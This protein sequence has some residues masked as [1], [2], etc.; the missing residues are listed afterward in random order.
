MTNNTA[1]YARY[2][3]ER[4]DGLF[5]AL[6]KSMSREEYQQN[7]HGIQALFAEDCPFMSL[8]YRKGAVL[9]RKMFTNVRDLREPEV[10][11]GIAEGL[12]SR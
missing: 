8:Y 5:T 2:S 9:T 3:S 10:L 6:R 12:E 1:N 7:L 11:R 4:M